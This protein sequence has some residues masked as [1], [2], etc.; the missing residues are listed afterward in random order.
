M[1]VRINH[2]KLRSGC[3]KG[4]G[5]WASSGQFRVRGWC[6]GAD[7]KVIESEK[8]WSRCN[9]PTR[10]V[11]ARKQAVS[12]TRIAPLMVLNPSHQRVSDLHSF[13]ILDVGPR[14]WAGRS[15]VIEKKGGSLGVVV[16]RGAF[17]PFV[18]GCFCFNIGG[19]AAAPAKVSSGSLDS[20]CS[21]AGGGGVGGRF[22]RKVGS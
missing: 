21:V 13:C 18:E 9:Q 22:G 10:T 7:G 20:P 8:E 6:D 14:L 2:Q 12:L 1:N 17:S 3:A 19:L 4:N 15:R 16:R 11:C 5:R